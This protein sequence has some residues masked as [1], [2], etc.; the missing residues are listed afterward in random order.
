MADD[1]EKSRRANRIGWLAICVFVLCWV[2]P[3]GFVRAYPP[4]GTPTRGEMAL[5]GVF[6]VIMLI[7]AVGLLGTGISAA[8]AIWSLRLKRQSVVGW[9][10]LGLDIAAA[11]SVLSF[12]VYL[13][14]H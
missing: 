2:V 13:Q 6:E 9:V 8:L 1:P 10:A 4:Q 12:W 3:V 14:I 11:L 5:I 7:A